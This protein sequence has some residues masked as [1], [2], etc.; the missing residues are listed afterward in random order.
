MMNGALRF[1]LWDRACFDPATI[2]IVATTAAVAGAGASAY[3]AVSSGQAQQASANYQAQVAANNA[4]IAN[5]NALQATAAGNA[6]AEQSRMKTNALIG[7]QMAG[8]ASSGIDT[9]SGSALDVRTSQK[10]IGELDVETIRNNA[11][12]QAYGF[13]TQSMGDT[14]QSALDTAQGGF[15]ATAGDIGG[16]SSIL[17]GAASA[18]SKYADWTKAAGNTPNTGYVDS[19]TFNS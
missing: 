11:A 6:Q 10:E 9:G 13:R 14:A 17:G 8:Q 4:Q 2:A 1:G 19:G 15:A 3:G 7:E 18:G 5:Q 16:V 12:R